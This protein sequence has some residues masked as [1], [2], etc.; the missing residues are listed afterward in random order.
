MIYYIR[1]GNFGGFDRADSHVRGVNFPS[2]KRSQ[3]VRNALY[4]AV[5]KQKQDIQISTDKTNEQSEISSE[6]NTKTIQVS[7][8]K[9]N[10]HLPFL[11]LLRR[12]P[13]FDRADSHVRGV[14]FPSAKKSQAA[15]NALDF[16]GAPPLLLRDFSCPIRDFSYPTLSYPRF[17]LLRRSRQF[18]YIYMYMYV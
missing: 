16:A 15:R 5:H 8:D 4:F 18:I 2:A 14:N 9:I 7:T 10:E 1:L 17:L 6:T 13:G 3:T 11:L 12:S